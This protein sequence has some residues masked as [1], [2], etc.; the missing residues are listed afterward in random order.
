[1]FL[2]PSRR[3][4]KRT[5]WR[6]VLI[7]AIA[8]GALA[9]VFFVLPNID[10][11]NRVTYSLAKTETI[12]PEDVI[13]NESGIVYTTDTDLYVSDLKGNTMFEIPL[14][15]AGTQ[16]AASE[17][18]IC[19]YRDNNIKG[20]SY[21]QQE[22]FN[23][24]VASNIQEVRCGSDA[25]AVLCR[26]KNEEGA[27]V[28]YIYILNKKGEQTGQAEY[29]SRPVM[30]FGFYGENDTLYVLSIDASGVLPNS[31]IATY[32]TMGKATSNV[33]DNSQIIEKVY[34][35]VGGKTYALGT[36]TLILYDISSRKLTESLVYGWEAEAALTG[37]PFYIALR[38]R[39]GT[40][41][42]ALKVYDA[43]LN[44]S[45]FYLPPGVFGAAVNAEGL[46]AF[47]ENAIYCYTLAGESVKTMTFNTPIARARQIAGGTAVCWDEEG[48][49]YIAE[50]NIG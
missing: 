21:T 25:L 17:S 6:I 2:R 50:L 24:S 18:M 1:M 30:D 45:V 9:F 11:S 29:V 39:F 41:F 38:P 35:G 48:E 19:T 22:L 47:S 8:A 3:K 49:S 31:N 44:E 10:F 5:L 23:T 33:T 26:S 15:A 37:D 42:D 16:V 46:Y 20:L 13:G 32:T 12:F 34:V 4:Q 27:D 43:D 28:D 36:N 7:A 14:D 40:N